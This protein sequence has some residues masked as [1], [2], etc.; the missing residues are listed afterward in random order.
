MQYQQTTT[1]LLQ[2]LQQ[3]EQ[4]NNRAIVNLKK[5]VGQI[6]SILIERDQEI[7]LSEPEAN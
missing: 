5:Q 3:G 6:A 2:I 4:A 1:Q 7:F